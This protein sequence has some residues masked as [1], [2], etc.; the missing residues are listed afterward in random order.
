MLGVVLQETEALLHWESS[1]L[2]FIAALLKNQEMRS[3]YSKKSN[4]ALKFPSSLDISE[5]NLLIMRKSRC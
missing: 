2:T 4:D 5:F 3:S 1:S